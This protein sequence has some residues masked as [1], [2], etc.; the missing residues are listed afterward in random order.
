VVLF[1]EIRNCGCGVVSLYQGKGARAS[2]LVTSC[3]SAT[4]PGGAQSDGSP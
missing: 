2:S 3:A 1:M 4:A